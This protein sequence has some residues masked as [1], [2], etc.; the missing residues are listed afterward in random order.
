MTKSYRSINIFVSHPFVP[1]NGV[2]DIEKFRTNITLLISK[3]ENIVRKEY[4]DF[5]IDATFFFT[6]PFTTLPSQIEQEIRNC[7]LAIVDI[8]ENKPN[9]FFEYGLLYGLN[10]P[11][12]LIKTEA[13]MVDFPIPADLKDRFPI[14]YKGFDSLIETVVNKLA[15]AFKKILHNDSLAN[16]YLNKIW[17]PTD[18][19]TIHLVAPVETEKPEFASTESRNYIFLN[20]LQDIDSVLEV[21]NFLNRTYR[22]TKICMYASDEFSKHTDENLVIIGGPGE[23]GDGNAICAEIMELMDVKINYCFDEEDETMIYDGKTFTAEYKGGKITKDYGYFARFPNPLNPRA[24]VILIHGIH[25]FGVLGAAKV[26]SDIPAAQGNIRKILKKLNLDDIKEASFECFFPV[27]VFKQ[28]V[29]CPEIE[30]IHI[31]PLTKK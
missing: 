18:V 9:I 28:T 25:T 13:S 20:N 5:D 26:L 6:D 21:S 19:G 29:M 31:L 15:E 4:Q 17:F 3:A 22:N 10:I 27:N 12:I 7:H 14:V 11:T 8:T 30:Y 2:Y 23:D 1:N 16:I 24:S